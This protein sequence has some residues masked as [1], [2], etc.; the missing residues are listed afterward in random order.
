[1]TL[2]IVQVQFIVIIVLV[3]E[4]KNLGRIIANGII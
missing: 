4:M 3:L 1:M 2:G